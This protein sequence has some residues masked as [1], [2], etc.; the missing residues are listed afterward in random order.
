MNKL[1]KKNNINLHILNASGKFGDTIEV[2]EK[3]VIDALECV[4]EKLEIKNVDI[5][6]Q[7][8]PIY[9]IPGYGVNCD[10]PA[11]DLI[12]L[13]F[14]PNET[15]FLDL[16]KTNT[17]E[18]IALA[19]FVL[20]RRRFPGYGTTL[21]DMMVSEG[22]ANHFGTEINSDKQPMWTNSLSNEDLKKYLDMAK[23]NFDITVY[24]DVFYKWFRG[25][26]PEI[27]MWAGY[28]IAYHIISEYLKKNPVNSISEIVEIKPEVIRKFWDEK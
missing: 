15:G 6:L 8:E 21:F 10:C 19:S 9:I 5:V 3:E 17:K 20:N 18:L 28:N 12:H 11:D 7:V 26:T 14:N 24:P 2:I 23:P 4:N 13:Y 16:I 25:S 1:I 22:L 27:P